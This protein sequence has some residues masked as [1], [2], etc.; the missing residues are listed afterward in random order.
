[1]LRG[2]HAVSAG[3]RKVA[4]GTNIGGSHSIIKSTI[5]GKYA[6]AKTKLIMTKTMNISQSSWSDSSSQIWVKSQKCKGVTTKKHDFNCA[7][8]G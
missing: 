6:L 3:F 5:I 8:V 1:M 7:P 2:A 4:H